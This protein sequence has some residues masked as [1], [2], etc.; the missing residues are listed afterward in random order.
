[1]QQALAEKNTD[2]VINAAMSDALS[3]FMKLG[4]SSQQASH[5]LA[6]AIHNAGKDSD[7]ATLIR[8]GLR[9]LSQ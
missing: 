7:S 5:A 2:G 1:M 8:A 9:E 3:V 6:H 4:Y